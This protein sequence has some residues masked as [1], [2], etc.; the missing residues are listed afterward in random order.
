MPP[1]SIL[2]KP[3]SSKCNLR[4][5]YCFYNS[6]SE[7]RDTKDYGF[8]NEETITNLVKNILEYAD[9]HCVFAFQGGEPT[10]IGLDFYRKVIELQK[11]YN[12]KGVRIENTIQTN[13]ILIDEEWAKFFYENKFLIG[14]SLD[15]SK[16]INDGSRLDVNEKSTFN[17]VM[18][19]IKLLDKYKVNYNILC[20]VSSYVARHIGKVYS[21]YK[22]NGFKFLQFMPCLDENEESKFY[23]LDNKKYGKFLK[24]LFDL[25]YEDFV[26]GERIDIRFFSNLVQMAAGYRS[27]T[28]G[29]SGKCHCYFVVEGDGSIYPCDFYVTDNWLLGNVNNEKFKDIIIS[30]KAEKFVYDSIYVDDKCRACDYFNLCRG[31]CRRWREP[32]E[33]VRPKLNKLCPAFKE[34]FKYADE[35]IYELSLVLKR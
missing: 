1:I 35:R 33:D 5:K 26:K 31:G 20:V 7:K 11:R 23:S 19:S 15:G 30:E 8:M 27:E 9:D 14:V 29:M 24:N 34:F 10:L 3:S 21:F 16:D 32:F 13:G 28:C 18:N 6:L 25:W 2:I 22:R 17:R 4:C 12:H